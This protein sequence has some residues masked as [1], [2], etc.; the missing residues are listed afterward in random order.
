MESTWGSK[1]IGSLAG[2]E[3]EDMMSVLGRACPWNVELQK[4][5]DEL[6]APIAVYHSPR[7]MNEPNTIV[8]RL[9]SYTDL[10]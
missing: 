7:G 2:N 3:I 6:R 10:H 5:A 8:Y 1:A 4:F 9:F